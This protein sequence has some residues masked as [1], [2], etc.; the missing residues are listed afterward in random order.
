MRLKD[1]DDII[2]KEVIRVFENLGLK[3]DE[4]LVYL[5]ILAN[6]GISALELHSELGISLSKLYI[7]LKNLEKRNLIE[8]YGRRKKVYVAVKPEMHILEMLKE[9][10]KEIKRDME[11]MEYFLEKIKFKNRR[12]ETPPVYIIRKDYIDRIKKEMRNAKAEILIS[13]PNNLVREL[14]VNIERAL[15]K[16][17][18][19][20]VVL[21]SEIGIDFIL[22]FLKKT[23]GPITVKKRKTYGVDIVIIDRKK[24]FILSFEKNYAILIEDLELVKTDLRVFYYMLWIPSIVILKKIARPNTMLRY[25]NMWRAIDDVKVFIEKGYNVEA[26]V[27]GRYVK[28]GKSFKC[29]GNVIDFYES[30]DKIIYNLT[31][32]FNGKKLTVGGVGAKIEDIEAFEIY[33]LP[34]K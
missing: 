29:K 28:S 30:P 24:S 26:Y 10:E 21:Y 13:L 18:V 2:N 11:L 6:D 31:I 4:A 25:V 22:N 15:K 17:I 9:K 8:G 14:L 1:R 19:V 20:S 33:L 27:V 5:K 32:E 16:N 7:I 12:A 34:T 3:K 23:Q